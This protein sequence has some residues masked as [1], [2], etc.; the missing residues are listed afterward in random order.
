MMY[1]RKNIKKKFL[2]MFNYNGSSSDSRTLIKDILHVPLN[3]V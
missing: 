3:K 1:G 2:F